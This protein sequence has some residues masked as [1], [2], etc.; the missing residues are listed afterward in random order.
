MI[1]L[2][3]IALQIMRFTDKEIITTYDGNRPQGMPIKSV[4][5]HSN[6]RLPLVFCSLQQKP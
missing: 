2:V 3:I 4:K 6:G 5:K 1:S